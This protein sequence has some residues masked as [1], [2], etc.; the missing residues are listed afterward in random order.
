MNVVYIVSKAGEKDTRLILPGTA[1]SFRMREN[2]TNLGYSVH[3]TDQDPES[4]VRDELEKARWEH[5]FDL[6]APL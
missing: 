6:A 5:L 2:L 3:A 1:W 4:V